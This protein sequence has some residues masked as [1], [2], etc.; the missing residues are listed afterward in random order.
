[1]PTIQN[2]RRGIG[3]VIASPNMCKKIGR[4][5]VAGRV[6]KN[7]PTFRSANFSTKGFFI[8]GVT[9]NS[10]GAA[11][12]GCTIQLFRT[13]DDLYISEVISDGSGNYS[14]PATAGPYYIVAYK[15]GAPDVGGTSVNTLTGI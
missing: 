7:I 13:S 5:G 6:A 14:I 12:G 8:T 9:K 2:L 10:T 15:V 11:L 3:N 4:G 1:M